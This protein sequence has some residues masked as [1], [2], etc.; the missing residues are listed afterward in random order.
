MVI[1]RD[2]PCLLCPI[3]CC[4]RATTAEMNIPLLTADS[5][6]GASRRITP[7]LQAFLVWIDV[8]KDIDIP[9]SLYSINVCAGATAAEMNISLLTADFWSVLAGVA[10]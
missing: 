7:Q 2:T 5:W 10:L 1:Y 3:H 4:A 9:C 8:Y 6:F